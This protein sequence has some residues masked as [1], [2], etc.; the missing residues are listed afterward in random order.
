MPVLT[1]ETS[2]LLVT[3]ATLVLLLLHTPRPEGSLRAVVCPTTAQEMPAIGDGVALT[4][5]NTLIIAVEVP[6][7]ACILNES[8]PL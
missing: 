3:V 4:V 7:E 6:A 8:S 2:P 5:T 1:P